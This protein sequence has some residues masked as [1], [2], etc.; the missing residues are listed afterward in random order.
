MDPR[1]REEIQDL[2]ET[3]C[4][5]FPEI[6]DLLAGLGLRVF[7]ERQAQR[8]PPCLGRSE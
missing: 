2:R 7:L 8:D 5:V 4:V 1:D 3:V 6:L